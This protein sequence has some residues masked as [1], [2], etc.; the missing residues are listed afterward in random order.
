MIFYNKIFD[1]F[2]LHKIKKVII[3]YLIYECFIR[4]SIDSMNYGRTPVIYLIR[5]ARSVYNTAEANLIKQFPNLSTHE[6]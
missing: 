5:H 3:V 2:M 6:F 4:L 1:M